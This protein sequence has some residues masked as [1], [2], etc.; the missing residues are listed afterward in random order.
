MYEYYTA[1]LHAVREGLLLLDTAGRVQLVNDEAR[2]LLD[3]P[4]DVV[5][6]PLADL[7]LRARAWS[8][9][10][11]GG[12]RSP[13][14]STSPATGCWSSARAPATW[15]GARRRRRGHPARPHRAARGDRRAR[16]GP[17]PHR[18]A[19]RAEP[20]G[21]QPAAHGGVAHRARPG[22]GGGRVRHRGAPGRPAARPTRWSARS[23]T[24]WSRR[25][26]S[27]RPPRP[28]SAA[29]TCG[30]GATLPPAA[31][32]PA[33][34]L[35]TVLGNLVDNAFDAVAS[36]PRRRAR[37]STVEP[38]QRHHGRGQRPGPGRRGDRP[39]P[40]AR[41]D[42]QGQR[43]R[44]ASASRWSRQVARRHGGDVEIGRSGARRRPV[45][46]DAADERPSGCWSSRT[47]RSPP[48]RTRRTSGARRASRSPASP[49]RRATPRGSSTGDPRRRPGPARHA[50]ARRPRPRPA[51][52]AARRRPPRRRD[53]G[54]LGAR[55]RRGRDAVAQGVVLYLLKPFTF[56]TFRA[57]LEQYA[58]YRATLAR[59]SRAG[60]RPGR[61]RRAARL[62]AH[63]PRPRCPRG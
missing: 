18:V 11:S 42:D 16:R 7:G 14:T 38:R 63:A 55:R 34:D 6:R 10:R 43:R 61:G 5:G 35:V 53:R 22:R 39:R 1:V 51:P 47:R 58:A 62:A 60:A 37:G 44:T 25:C 32:Y 29:S 33:R 41:L 48:R 4:D 45:H 20:R 23:A 56:A 27:A 21:R 26:C 17:R 19:A 30:S 50:P 9:R 31:T 54:D 28:P 59:G 12:P 49:A 3:L 13:T 36:Q 24:R 57:K 40:R 46:G 15:E 2:R 8:R 52:A